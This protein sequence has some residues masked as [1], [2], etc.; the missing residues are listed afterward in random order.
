MN[1]SELYEPLLERRIDR[2]APTLEQFAREH[3]PESAL[4]AV[5]RF[6][7]ATFAPSE[8]ALHAML[9]AHSAAT[10][11]PELRTLDVLSACATYAAESRLPWSEPP[12]PD[13]PPIPEDWTFSEKELDEAVGRGDRLAAEQ[14]LTGAMRAEDFSGQFFSAAARRLDESGHNLVVAV[15]VWDLAA[16]APEEARFQLLRLATWEWTANGMAARPTVREGAGREVFTEL[17]NRFLAERGAI[18]PFN[19][20]ALFDAALATTRILG[21][22]RIERSVLQRLERSESGIPG[23][24][25]TARPAPA[26]R[27]ARDFGEYLKAQAMAPRLESGNLP[28]FDRE[29]FLDAAAW[30]LA[31][32]P[33]FEEWSF[34]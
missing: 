7:V 32:A 22:D 11:P 29:A 16:M 8:H 14:W 27:L 5:L 25:P 30:N 4:T 24:L 9:A 6:A 21:D 33:S 1:I 23:E 34:A 19:E 10:M 2:I 17:F 26:Y 15:A 28:R 20:I 3:G 13:P 18:V 12:L 31:N